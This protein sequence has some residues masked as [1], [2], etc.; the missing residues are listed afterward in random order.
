MLTDDQ[1]RE[2]FQAAG[3]ELALPVEGRAAALAAASGG[4][5]AAPARYD[6]RAAHRRHLTG[7]SVAAVALLVVG[8]VTGIVLGTRST[9]PPSAVGGPTALHPASGVASSGVASNGLSAGGAA[10]GSAPVAKVPAAGINPGGPNLGAPTPAS[11]ASGV[12]AKIASTGSLTLAI[13]RS[14]LNRDVAALRSL[15]MGAGGYISSTDVSEAASTGRASLTLSVP[16][17][18]FSSTISGAE[19]LG[20]VRTL[21]TRAEDVT[22]QYSGTAARLQAL[23]AVRS[24]LERLLSHAAKVSDLLDVEAQIEQVQTQID[25][26]QGEQ[27]SLDQEV[28]YATLT[29]DLQLRTPPHHAKPSALSRAWS[30]AISGFTGGLKWLLSI[31]G[32]L[33]FSLLLATALGLLGRFGWRRYGPRLRRHFL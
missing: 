11:K 28:T 9:P 12:P 22:G 16:A 7:L 33:L 19:H 15:A 26:L 5:R 27:R 3:D 18:A 29:V 24:Q 8:A 20:T 32:A 6:A 4:E 25:E 17:T 1:L 21:V 14:A 23:E 2:A 13:G 10:V 30:D 31:S